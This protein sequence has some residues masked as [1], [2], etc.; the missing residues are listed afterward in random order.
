MPHLVKFAEGLPEAALVLRIQL[1]AQPLQV[2]SLPH[3]LNKPPAGVHQPHMAVPGVGDLL[4]DLHH[5]RAAGGSTHLI[6][7]VDHDCSECMLGAGAAHH[8]K[9]PE[10]MD[11]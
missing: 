8:S 3:V 4:G 11:Q 7:H 10:D 5:K 1:Q 9:E 2:V 6:V